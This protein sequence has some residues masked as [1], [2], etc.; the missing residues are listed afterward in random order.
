[1]Q[2]KRPRSQG[3]TRD[4]SGATPPAPV[5]TKRTVRVRSRLVAG[6][7]VVGVIVL[8]AGA[9]AALS[10]SSDLAE[11][12]RL[13]T[14]SELNQRAVTLAHSLADERDAVTAYIAGGRA[15]D[16]DAAAANRLTR[17]TRVDQ[18]IDEI[19]EPAPAA[20]RRD[21][22][23]VPSLRRDALTGKGSALEAH[24]AY[25]EVIAKLHGIAAE[26]ADK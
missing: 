12:Q 24:Q 5:A 3:S 10:A 22:S 21:L 9:P 20:L 7:A 14:L 4:G 17:T 1:M 15:D 6:V 11:S 18:Q 16:G 19:H 2:K 25:S 23:T 26:L 13:V 8:A